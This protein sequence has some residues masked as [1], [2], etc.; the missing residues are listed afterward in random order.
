M[1]A[2]YRVMI[3]PA[4]TIDLH[5]T[6]ATGYEERQQWGGREGASTALFDQWLNTC[7]S[8][9]RIPQSERSSLDP[10]PSLPCI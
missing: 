10:S 3:G 2:L 4:G 1:E 8:S 7:A 6:S 5:V 9:V